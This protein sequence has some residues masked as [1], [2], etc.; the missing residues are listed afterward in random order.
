MTSVDFI[1]RQVIF[2]ILI[3]V[4]I[5]FPTCKKERLCENCING[6]QPPT[7][8]A[9]PDQVIT[10]PTDSVSLD[11]RQSSDPDGK[12]SEWLWTKISGPASFTIIKPTDSTTKVIVFVTGT[13]QFE[14]KVTDAGGLFAKDTVRIIVRESGNNS[15]TVTT[16]CNVSMTDITKLPTPGMVNY[17]FAAGAR[18]LFSR[19]VYGTVDIYDTLT[20]QW[21]TVN[22][23]FATSA[24][25]HSQEG[26]KTAK[27]GSK[28]IFSVMADALDPSRGQ[29]INI[30]DTS[31]NSSKITHLSQARSFYAM[32]VAGNKVFYAGGNNG[33]RKM[34]IYDVSSDSWS[35][36]DFDAARSGMS[37]IGFKDK[38]YFAGGF[39]IRHDSLVKVCDDYGAN[40]DSVP[41]WVASD[42]IDI[43][44]VSTNVWSVS[45][46]SE[47][48]GGIALGILGNKIVFAGGVKPYIDNF[49]QRESVSPVV[50]FYNTSDNSW[51]AS[52]YGPANTS[53]IEYDVNPH[54]IHIIGTKML[55][56]EAGYSS[57]IHIYDD[58]TSSWSVA[59]MPH[60]RSAD[61]LD[62]GK[63]VSVGN[64]LIFF[65]QYSDMSNSGYT[66]INIYNSSTNT[67]CH[68][69]LNFP[70][71][72]M[73]VVRGGNSVYIAGG[74]GAVAGCCNTLV[75]TVWQLM[76]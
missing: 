75:D 74:L 64:K 4:T 72:R 65:G 28:I 36:K 21:E 37:A 44:D 17:S 49:Y 71:W 10:L 12:I 68:T 33:S 29:L 63:I 53:M 59:Q 52:W 57:K 6:N 38:I 9:G 66:G 58:L 54:G 62:R 46:L 14:L 15:G 11:G 55:I 13:Y 26:Y 35:V 19:G 23:M 16:G 70:M 8:I 56:Q 45:H 20:R 73:G 50:D 48:R 2:V 67:W 40:C 60:S 32:A 43:W 7:A 39:N 22:G 30:Y 3:L 42:R 34:D 1:K 41:A 5:C 27:V 24:Y 25:L 61:M 47:A 51:S 31:T 76:F 69:Q 18:L